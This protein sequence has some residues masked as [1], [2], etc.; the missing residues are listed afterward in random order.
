[1]TL[2]ILLVKY[3]EYARS[4]KCREQKKKKKKK[5]NS[6]ALNSIFSAIAHPVKSQSSPHDFC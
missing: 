2:L 6:A 3:L 4:L 1:M 5:K